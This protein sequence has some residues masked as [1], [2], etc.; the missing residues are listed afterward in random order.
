MLACALRNDEI[1]AAQ[2]DIIGILSDYGFRTAVLKGLS[3]ARY[4]S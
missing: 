1:N 2:R 3:V 4:Y